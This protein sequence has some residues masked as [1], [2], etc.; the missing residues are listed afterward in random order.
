M[1]EICV[2]DVL[3]SIESST[4]PTQISCTGDVLDPRQYRPGCI[5]PDLGWSQLTPVHLL[6]L[7]RGWQSDLARDV[8]GFKSILF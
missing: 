6:K 8:L 5:R 2:G 3:D 7:G 4:S 1:H